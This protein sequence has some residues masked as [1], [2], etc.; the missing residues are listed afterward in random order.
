MTSIICLFM[1]IALGL[2]LAL[3]L[4]AWLD[5]REDPYAGIIIPQ[6]QTTCIDWS[7][8]KAIMARDTLSISQEHK[9]HKRI[10]GHL[11]KIDHKARERFISWMEIL[12]KRANDEQD[13]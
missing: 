7:L 4:Y 5:E 10:G 12:E 9:A 8:R 6:T 2:F 13:L 3:F 1:G 11:G